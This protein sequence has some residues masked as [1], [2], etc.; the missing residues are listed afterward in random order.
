MFGFSVTG[1]LRALSV[2]AIVALVA[3]C[4][5]GFALS[6]KP[7]SPQG[8]VNS[9]FSHNVINPFGLLSINN[10]T[11]RNS[12][13]F[14][15]CPATG[16]IKY[17]SDYYNSLINIYVGRFAGQGP[18][19]QIASGEV[20]RPSDVYVNPATHDLY[21]ANM[22]L[23]NIL[24]FHRGQT[25]PYNTYTDP[26]G[27]FP[28]GVVVA[29][30]GTIIATN[31]T[32]HYPQ[33]G[34]SLSTWIGGPNGGTFV[35]NFRLNNGN[36]GG[37][38][39]IRKDGTVYFDVGAYSTTIWSVSCPMGACGVQTQVAGISLSN[40]GGM[41]VDAEGDLVL[42]DASPSLCETFELPNPVPKTF[43][44]YG[45]PQGIAINK[46]DNHLFVADQND[47]ASEYSY[48][49][50]VMLGSVVVNP[51]N[52]WVFGIAVDP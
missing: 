44:V 15:A 10:R 42:A 14:Y 43:S 37:F 21:V 9:I 46:L 12:K 2:G 47:L 51:P 22:G 28:Q 7:A 16:S 20:Y 41:A 48:P 33:V 18:C 27:Q 8:G 3:G 29:K 31:F 39:T 6:P 23:S 5:G 13:S 36:F 30:D 32:A 26:S 1:G 52:A 25:T 49:S 45:H 17:V 38:I 24:V 19:G 4:S 50:G 11:G 35:G 40:S 34:G